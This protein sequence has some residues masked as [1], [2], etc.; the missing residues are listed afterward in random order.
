MSNIISPSREKSIGSRVRKM[1]VRLSLTQRELA[2]TAGVS[3]KDIKLL[4]RNVPVILDCKRKVLK[5]LWG[6]MAIREHR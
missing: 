4:E 2:W 1:R 3:E 5:T 6:E